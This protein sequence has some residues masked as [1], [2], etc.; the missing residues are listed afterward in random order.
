M[1]KRV[2]AV[3]TATIGIG[4]SFGT[5]GTAV[6]ALG[7]C[8][9]SIDA[10]AD[11]NAQFR[12]ARKGAVICLHGT[13]RVNAPLVPRDRQVIRGPATIVAAGG[14]E[15]GF[16]LRDAHHVTIA[17]LDISGFTSRGVRCGPSTRLLRSALHHNRQN[18]VGCQLDNRSGSHI[19]IASNRVYAN[20]DD[21][22]EGHTA[23]GMKFVRTGAPG[24]RA[25]T[26]VTVRRNKVWANV[27]NGIWFDIN[28]AGDL[29][30]RNEIWDNTRNGI[31]YE[32]SAGPAIIRRNVVYRN[33]WY[34]VWITSSAKVVVRE[35]VVVRNGRG[36][37]VVVS[38]ER[39]RLRFP[40]LGGS[41]DGYAIRNILIERN[42]VARH[43]V[44]CDLENVS[45]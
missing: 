5:S 10:P 37:I 20:G 40:D 16:F 31:R 41:H 24:D 7:P 38:D 25:G 8:D 15:D 21:S 22:I 44:G 45:C 4:A 17:G 12:K 30:A 1:L 35:N 2:I 43:L 19:V 26:A 33:Q 42:T 34:G 23:G 3:I 13:F 32:I 28:S 27:G 6:A 14:V 9:V 11:L 39:A 29:I 36:D 18:G